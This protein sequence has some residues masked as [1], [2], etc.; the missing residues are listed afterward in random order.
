MLETDCAKH[1]FADEISDKLKWWS[2]TQHIER[3]WDVFL[4][5]LMMPCQP[6]AATNC[7]YR[8][9]ILISS[10]AASLALTASDSVSC[11]DDDRCASW[12]WWWWWW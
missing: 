2:S 7:P 11:Y 6:E 5:R 1:A 3:C 4:S 12:W 10:D 8:N 9:L